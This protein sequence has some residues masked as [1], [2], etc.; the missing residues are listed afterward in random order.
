MIFVTPY[1]SFECVFVVTN[2]R[3]IFVSNHPFGYKKVTTRTIASV[4]KIGKNEKKIVRIDGTKLEGPEQ[5]I[6]MMYD[7]ITALWE[8]ERKVPLVPDEIKDKVKERDK[9]EFT[10]SSLALLNKTRVNLDFNEDDWKLITKGAQLLNFNSDDVIIKKGELST[11][12]YQIVNG[13]IV[14]GNT[15]GTSKNYQNI[16]YKGDLFGVVAF[17]NREASAIVK[18]LEKTQVFVIEGYYLNIL[19]QHDPSLAGRFFQHLAKIMCD[20]L[21]K[22]GYF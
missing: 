6:A 16:Y 7:F 17:L 3:F 13:S 15:Y 19:F 11:K 12:I 14:E 8:R 9:K 2:L 20:M 1:V 21:I 5:T 18:T 22:A 10:I 4:Q